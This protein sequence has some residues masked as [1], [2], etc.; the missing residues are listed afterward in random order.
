MGVVACIVGQCQHVGDMIFA[1]RA[2]IQQF[3]CQRIDFIVDKRACNQSFVFIDT[4]VV[5]FVFKS[6]IS[7]FGKETVALYRMDR[8]PCHIGNAEVDGIPV[9]ILA[10]PPWKLAIIG[11]STPFSGCVVEPECAISG[12]SCCKNGSVAEWSDGIYQSLVTGGYLQLIGYRRGQEMGRRR[13]FFCIIAHES[14]V[15]DTT[16]ST[17]C[18]YIHPS[19]ADNAVDR[20]SGACINSGYG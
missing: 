5:K 6:S 20:R 10:Y 11:R 4:I 9:V 7:P 17:Q 16:H 1:H 19:F 18:R 13:A 15:V 14:G 8:S 12:M 3:F 2:L